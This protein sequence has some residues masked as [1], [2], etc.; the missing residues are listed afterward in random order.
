MRDNKF[1]TG[2][3]HEAKFKSIENVLN[4][5]SRRLGRVVSFNIPPSLLTATI[6]LPEGKGQF[7]W[8]I[9][10]E[11]QVLNGKAYFY[12]PAI[13]SGIVGVESGKPGELS[14]LMRQALVKGAREV[15]IPLV[16]CAEGSVLTLSADISYSR[17][18]EEAGVP[19]VVVGLAFYAK[20]KAT[21]PNPYDIEAINGT[22]E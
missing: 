5:F 14:T 9:P 22:E 11:G 8:M 21:I 16:N 1:V 4:R 18:S 13:S 17:N 7:S 6:Q 19:Y 15:T 20:A 10:C 2:D 12:G 3:S